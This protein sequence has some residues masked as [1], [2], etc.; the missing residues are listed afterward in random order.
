[1]HCNIDLE[2]N[3]LKSKNREK[4]YEYIHYT[5]VQFNTEINNNEICKEKLEEGIN[6]FIDN[7]NAL[8]SIISSIS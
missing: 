8:K 1:M 4:Y 3:N 5:E 7:Y 6:K 2:L